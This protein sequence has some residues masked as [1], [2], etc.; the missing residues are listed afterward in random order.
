M[1][2]KEAVVELLMDR[3]DLSEEDAEARY[4]EI[5]KRFVRALESG[6]SELMEH[7]LQKDLGISTSVIC[8]EAE[9]DE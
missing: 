5:R 2:D 6:N 1:P 7:I 3:F 9:D 8:M 4:K